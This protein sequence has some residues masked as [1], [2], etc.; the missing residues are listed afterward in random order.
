LA[1]F[2]LVTP[3]MTGHIFVPMYLY[4]AK[5]DLHAFIRPSGIQK[6]LE[7]LQCRWVH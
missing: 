6:C 2:G 4:W 5:I 3:E 7:V 1:N